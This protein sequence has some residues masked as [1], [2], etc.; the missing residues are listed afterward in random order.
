MCC[1]GSRAAQKRAPAG[2][3]ETGEIRGRCS[4]GGEEGEN[5]SPSICSASHA[6]RGGEDAADG[7][8]AL[9]ESLAEAL[10]GNG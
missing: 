9:W 3:T 4:Q 6:Q 8:K 2:S 10:G 7:G 1:K 5:R